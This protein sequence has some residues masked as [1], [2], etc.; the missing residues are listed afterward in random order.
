MPTTPEQRLLE[1]TGHPVTIEQL[2][3]ELTR[4]TACFGPPKDRTEKQQRQM[5]GEWFRALRYF[6]GLAVERAI[7]KLL[8]T[9]KWFPTLAEVHALC[10]ADTDGWKDALG[11]PRY[12][13]PHQ[14][15]KPE[16]FVREGRTEAE[17]IAHRDAVIA[18]ARSILPYVPALNYE[19]PADPPKPASRAEWVSEE[20]KATA[21][22]NGYWKGQPCKS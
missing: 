2:A 15:W 11:V 7:D 4:L 18:Q 21:K 22:K 3:I 10:A 14:D 9:S 20:L 8:T 16:P 6:G 17:E 12:E 5:A 13:P 1:H 19:P